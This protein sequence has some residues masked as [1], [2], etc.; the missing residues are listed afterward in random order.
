MTG[1]VLGTPSLNLFLTSGEWLVGF[2]FSKLGCGSALRQEEWRAEGGTLLLQ[3]GCWQGSPAA[4]LLAPGTHWTLPA[5]RFVFGACCLACSFLPSPELWSS[6]PSHLGLNFP[7]SQRSSLSTRVDA[8]LSSTVTLPYCR[9][10]SSEIVT[11]QRVFS[12]SLIIPPSPK[13]GRKHQEGRNLACRVWAHLS[14]QDIGTQ[15]V[16]NK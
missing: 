11:I 3:R 5:R 6:Y 7:S 2:S 14:T 8:H 9:L 16:L 4:F 15:Q 12:L 10:F 1:A 13:L